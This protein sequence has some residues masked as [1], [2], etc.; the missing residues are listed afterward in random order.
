MSKKVRALLAFWAFFISLS[1]QAGV[2]EKVLS[3]AAVEKAI[4]PRRLFLFVGINSFA[5]GQYP[6]LEFP[7]KDVDDFQNFIQSHNATDQDYV[8][9]LKGQEA[10]LARVT[11]AL[12]EIERRNLSERDMVFVYLST[13]GT[14]DFS[15][16]RQMERYAVVYDTTFK[17]TRDNGL[18]I[19]W[20]ENR[21]R[22]LRSQRKALILALCHSGSGKSA[23]P[24]AIHDEL[25][26]MKGHVQSK[27]LHEASSAMMVLS[28]SSWGEPARENR[29]LR[30]DVY[31]HFLLKGL[32]KN[33]ANLDGAVSLFEAHEYA[34]S[35]TY[36]FTRGS[37]TPT[38][39]VN[40][41]GMDPLILK[42][43][44]E[45]VGFPLIFADS[46]VWRNLSLKING[47]LKG[48]LW[49]PRQAE[50]GH[51]RVALLDPEHPDQP[52]MDHY[53]YLEPHQSYSVT[54]LLARKSTWLVQVILGQIPVDLGVDAPSLRQAT[55]LGLGVS[56]QAILA[57]PFTASIEYHRLSE[58]SKKTV[59][60]DVSDLT[61]NAD[62]IKAGIGF[63]TYWMPRLLMDTSLS[64]EYLTIERQIGNESYDQRRQNLRIIYPAIAC[65]LRAI[66]LVGS[67]FAGLGAVVYPLRTK[68][69][70]WDERRDALRPI[71][72]R[73]T[74]G[75]TL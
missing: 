27:P 17:Q 28:A 16:T 29:V 68:V 55:S 22:R 74:L 20:L 5:D 31:T 46:E 11:E 32:Q 54:S 66:N 56:L 67:W 43:K 30:N 13:H 18:S 73:V 37:Q 33:D 57:T 52:L 70:A 59:D 2:S 6:A 38:A 48:S 61:Y 9:T 69:V 49:Q 12:D 53:M 36:D 44:V 21:L 39:L 3:P 34:R 23:L 15:S 42:G 1:A 24:S 50:E 40:L 65:E 35:M 58:H 4:E 25:K 19:A 51:V 10:T 71:T 72:G 63:S 41:K 64:L 26:S 8:I 14:L 60:Y 75:T 45:Q 62:L 7:Q 47:R